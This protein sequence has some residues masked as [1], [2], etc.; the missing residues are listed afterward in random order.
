MQHIKEFDVFE[1]EHPKGKVSVELQNQY[2]KLASD[3][4]KEFKYFFSRGLFGHFDIMEMPAGEKILIY[5]PQDGK[6]PAIEFNAFTIPSGQDPKT[7]TL[8][9]LVLTKNTGWKENDAE[10]IKDFSKALDIESWDKRYMDSVANSFTPTSGIIPGAKKVWFFN[11]PQYRYFDNFLKLLLPMTKYTAPGDIEEVTID[12]IKATPEFMEL[13]NFGAYDDTSDRIWKNK[14]FRI[15][16]PDLAYSGYNWM[17]KQNEEG[18]NSVTIYSEGP[19]RT[20][21]GGRPSVINSAPGFKIT[22]LDGWR[23]KIDWVKKYLMKRIAKDEFD[24]KSRKKQEELASLPVGEYFAAL[25][26]IDDER[27]LDWLLSHNEE[28]VNLVLDSGMDLK[29]YIEKD[30]SKAAVRLK[31]IYKHPTVKKAVDALDGESTKDFADSI[32]LTGNLGEIGF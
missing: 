22:N 21:S 4:K 7:V 25:L 12:Q 29:D 10:A 30:P 1:A 9:D 32:T 23:R 16:H 2:P 13:V 3:I 6:I 20:A 26:D 5:V 18:M 14:N 19:I 11:T 31:K 24:I 8:P 28:F 27:F 17:T 15:S